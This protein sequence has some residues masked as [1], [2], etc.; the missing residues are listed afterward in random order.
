MRRGA[1]NVIE[2]AGRN[3]DGPN[4]VAEW[5]HGKGFVTECVN[6]GAVVRQDNGVVVLT[7]MGLAGYRTAFGTRN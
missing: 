6:V 5:R 4:C 3:T 7:E 1:W 2:N